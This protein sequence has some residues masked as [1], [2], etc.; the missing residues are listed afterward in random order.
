MKTIL[1]LLAG[2]MSLNAGAQADVVCEAVKKTSA[3]QILRGI[4]VKDPITKYEETTWFGTDSAL[5]DRAGRACWEV[6]H[7]TSCVGTT[8]RPNDRYMNVGDPGFGPRLYVEKSTRA[9]VLNLEWVPSDVL[10]YYPSDYSKLHGKYHAF[11]SEC[12]EARS[13][14]AYEVVENIQEESVRIARA[15][16]LREH[17]AEE[18]SE[19][20]MVP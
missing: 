11:Y 3:G 12:E 16:Y 6:V 20:R 9:G 14:L 4:K 15:K 1:V 8:P 10:K 17:P 19:W 5:R 13:E 18:G 7:A 2:V